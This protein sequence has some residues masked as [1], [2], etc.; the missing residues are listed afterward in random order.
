MDSGAVEYA[1][2][3]QVLEYSYGTCR[4]QSSPSFSSEHVGALAVACFAFLAW[5]TCITFADEVDFLWSCV[6]PVLYHATCELI[7]SFT[8]KPRF[9]WSKAAFVVLRYYALIIV[10]S[11]Q[12]SLPEHRPD[13]PRLQ[14]ERDHMERRRM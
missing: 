6:Q 5:E 8:S 2:Q 13:T 4:I 10:L 11:V 7:I 9:R 14:I 3:T 12:P 1:L